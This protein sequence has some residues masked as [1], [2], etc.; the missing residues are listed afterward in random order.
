MTKATQ[1]EF[2]QSDK[3]GT[4]LNSTALEEEMLANRRVEMNLINFILKDESFQFEKDFEN[5]LVLLQS[6]CGAILE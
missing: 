1:D 3:T 5:E 2:Q 4:Y 6:K